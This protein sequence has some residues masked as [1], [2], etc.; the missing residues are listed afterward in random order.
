MSM[1]ADARLYASAIADVV[2]VNGE[3][4]VLGTLVSA[5]SVGGVMRPPMVCQSVESIISL[6]PRANPRPSIW[7]R[8]PISRLAPA[9]RWGNALRQHRV[10]TAS[11]SG[12]KISIHWP[13]GWVRSV[14][15]REITAAHNCER[16][17]HR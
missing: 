12:S 16:G 14:V 10:A 11:R 4:L 15:G 3:G 8:Q 7:M 5:L 17:A 1:S 2:M 13:L 6:P 9:S